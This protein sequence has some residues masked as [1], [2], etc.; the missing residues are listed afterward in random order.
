M[1]DHCQVLCQVG[2]PPCDAS[3][4]ATA[5]LCMLMHRDV[6]R[7]HPK[8][9]GM[10]IADVEVRLRFSLPAGRVCTSVSRALTLALSSLTPLCASL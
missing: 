10:Q 2:L 8:C 4:Q 1:D 7:Y 9:L 6:C 5:D 3:H